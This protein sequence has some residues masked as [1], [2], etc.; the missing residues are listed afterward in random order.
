MRNVPQQQQK[1]GLPAEEELELERRKSD[2]SHTTSSADVGSFLI[3][4]LRKKSGA[5]VR[6]KSTFGMDVKKLASANASSFNVSNNINS[7]ALCFLILL[8]AQ[9]VPI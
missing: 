1:E 6:L 5:A 3:K 2:L 4:P 7:S 8:D 9:R